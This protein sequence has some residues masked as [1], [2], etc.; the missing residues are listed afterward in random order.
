VGTTRD[1]ELERRLRLWKM[2]STVTGMLSAVIA[3]RLIRSAYRSIRKDAPRSAF[4]TTSDR[5]SLSN[6]LLWAV[7]AGVGVAVARIVSNRVV[8]IGW[9]AATGSAPP[10][11][12]PQSA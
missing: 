7:A 2:T 5:F 3:K 1:P 6:A 4:D 8:A 9:K 11:S 12:L 10:T